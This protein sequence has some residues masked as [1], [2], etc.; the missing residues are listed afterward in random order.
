MVEPEM[1]EPEVVVVVPIINGAWTDSKFSVEQILL[2]RA[3]VT[4]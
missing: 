1:V 2:I 3:C 4:C